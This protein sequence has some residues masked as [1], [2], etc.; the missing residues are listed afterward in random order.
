MTFVL[1]KI[2]VILTP[3]YELLVKLLPYGHV[4]TPDTRVAKTFIGLWIALA[5]GLSAMFSGEIRKCKNIWIL[6]FLVFIPLNIHLAPKYSIQLNG[7]DSTNYWVWKPFVMMLC[8]FIM[9]L[10][11]Q[12]LNITKET[13]KSLFG[14]IVWCGFIMAVYMILQNF[15]WDQFFE[16]K[17][18][19]AYRTVTK[20]ITV[21]TLGNSTLVSPFV[22]MIIPLALYLRHISATFPQ[23]KKP[24]FIITSWIVVPTLIYAVWLS[25][26]NMAIGAMIV[27][28]ILYSCLRWKMRGVFVVY[29]ALVLS[30]SV[31][32][33]IRVLNHSQFNKMETKI[34]AANGRIAVWKEIIRIAKEEKLGNIRN[35]SGNVIKA[36]HPFTGTGIGSY[37]VLIKQITKSI[38]G[39]AH[40]E[41]LEVFVTMGIGGFVLLMLSIMFMLLSS[42][43]AFFDDFNRDELAAL[44]SSFV[45]I[46][47]VALGTFPWQIAPII[48][49]TVVIVGLLHNRRI[50]KGV[51]Q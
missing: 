3:Y 39:Q 11:V 21:G 34:T 6:F 13:L 41:Y 43:F 23:Q 33:G 7:V 8:Y 45:C 9:F 2:G 12:S 22:A 44:L 18:G 16:S 4:A 31:L 36:R 25:Q 5:I 19:E 24:I 26:S 20:P 47:L 27:S 38:F 32:N 1:L 42:M 46:A 51:L 49:Y 15:G 10:G 35:A 14:T 40:N 50:L 17:T 29:L 48:F 28:L 37:P 30:F